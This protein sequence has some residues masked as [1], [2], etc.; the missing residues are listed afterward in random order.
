M[1]R[2]TSSRKATSNL[3]LSALFPVYK[4]NR[5]EAVYGNFL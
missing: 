2:Q 1:I 4:Y 3:P 5:N